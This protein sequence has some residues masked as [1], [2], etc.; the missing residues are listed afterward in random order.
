M[1][2]YDAV[3]NLQLAVEGYELAGHEHV[4]SPEFTRKTTVVR[5]HG[6][7]RRGSARMSPTTRP[8]TTRCSPAAP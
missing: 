2:L 5:L 4:I 8:S 1:S 7:A 6:R 3:R